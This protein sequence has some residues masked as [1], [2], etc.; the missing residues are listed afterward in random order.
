MRVA[1]QH[2]AV[3]EGAGVALVSVAAGVLLLGL[4]VG[5]ELPLAARGEAGAAAA[6][7]ARSQ[8]QVDDF[9]GGHLGEDLAK[10]G[11]AILGNVLVDVLGVD[12]AAVAQGDTH[13][14]GVEGGLIEGLGGVVIHHSLLVQQA[15]DNTALEQVLGDDFRHVLHGD[16]AVEGALGIDHHNGAQRAQ[17]KAAGADDVYFLLKAL[18]LDFFLQLFNN[19][20]A[21]GGSTACTSADQHV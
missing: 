3:H 11:V 16:A 10:G 18:G 13:L 9:L 4:G 14:L 17:A 5:G 7:Q 12:D 21:V 2:G 1:L 15:L 6:A 20:L 19:L 8:H